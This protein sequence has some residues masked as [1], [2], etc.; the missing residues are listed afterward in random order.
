VANRKLV[1]NG[2]SNIEAE[3]IRWPT[4]QAVSRSGF[5]S[6]ARFRKPARAG[7]GRGV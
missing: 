6:W 3:N 2:A 7:G 1:A 5:I 4:I